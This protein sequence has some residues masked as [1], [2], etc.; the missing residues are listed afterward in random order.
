MSLSLCLSGLLFSLC[1]F[2][3]RLFY[4][5]SET[6]EVGKVQRGGAGGGGGGRQTD[7]QTGRQRE[8]KTKSEFTQG[9][10]IFTLTPE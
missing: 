6:E 10:V 2:L 9:K 5:C 7:R 1:V 8:T 3:S 4:S